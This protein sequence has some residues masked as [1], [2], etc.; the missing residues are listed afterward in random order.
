MRSKDTVNVKLL[1]TQDDENG[2]GYMSHL[3]VGRP[4]IVKISRGEKVAMSFKIGT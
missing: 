1:L 4:S 3:V 2:R